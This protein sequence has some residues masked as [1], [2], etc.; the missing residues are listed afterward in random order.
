MYRK[1]QG[2]IDYYNDEI[3]MYNYLIDSFRKILSLFNYKEFNTPMLEYVD[4][5]KRSIGD[6][7][8]IVEKEMYV[9]T[10]ASGKQIAL[11]PENTAGVIRSYIENNLSFTPGLKRYFYIGAQFR[12][13]RPQK[14]RLRQFHQVGCETIGSN[15]P[16][17]D[18][19]IIYMASEFLNKIN[20]N[21]FEIQINSIGCMKCRPL[22]LEK[23]KLYY[24]DVLDEICQN[25]N[26]RFEK[27]LLRLFDCKNNDCQKHKVNAPKITDNLCEECSVHFDNLKNAMNLYNLKYNINNTLVR[28]LDYYTNT[29]FE[30]VNNELGAQ[31]AVLAGGR[32]NYL[33]GLLGGKDEPAIGFAA[34]VER[35]ILSLSDNFV[36]YNDK[37]IFIALQSNNAYGFAVKIASDIRKNKNIAVEINCLDKSLKAQMRMANKLNFDYLIVLGEEEVKTGNYKI[38]DLKTGTEEVW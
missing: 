21:N 3:G 8:D 19:E 26:N 22:Y 33:I 10:S 36:Q 13:E 11:R 37:K 35:L 7:T 24:N 30:F 18:A 1:I 5:F 28:G 32:Y 25:C 38:K 29:I 27:N 2:T 6:L 23:L 9:F 14:G 20:V 4:L 31:N 16:F 17:L 15:S 34:G 12:R